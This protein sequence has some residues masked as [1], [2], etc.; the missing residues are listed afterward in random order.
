[1]AGPRDGVEG[2]CC[3]T[4]GGVVSGRGVPREELAGRTGLVEGEWFGRIESSVTLVSIK[5]SLV[6]DS[7]TSGLAVS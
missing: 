4:E 6:V 2:R 7:T 1:M 3:V 5:I